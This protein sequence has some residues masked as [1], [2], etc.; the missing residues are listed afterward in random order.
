MELC[1]ALAQRL[2]V[3]IVEQQQDL[4]QHDLVALKDPR[5]VLF[6]GARQLVEAMVRGLDRLE[7][8][9]PGGSHQEGGGQ[10]RAENDG[11]AQPRER[12]LGGACGGLDPGNVRARP[13]KP[14]HGETSTPCCSGKV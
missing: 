6:D 9:H 4:P 1:L 7:V 11:D 3:V 5:R 8:A 12:A 2:I 10:D 14:L 13:A